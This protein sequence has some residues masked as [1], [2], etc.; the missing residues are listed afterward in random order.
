MVRLPISL[1]LDLRLVCQRVAV[2]ISYPGRA[3]I[4]LKRLGL[5]LQPSRMLRCAGLQVPGRFPIRARRMD[6][7]PRPRPRI[8]D[9]QRPEAAS[10]EK[11]PKGPE[12]TDKNLNLGVPAKLRQGKEDAFMLLARR[13]AAMSKT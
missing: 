6:K 10:T 7:T 1:R 4:R 9:K 2:R 8:I 5:R 3:Q 12:P 11:V 13:N